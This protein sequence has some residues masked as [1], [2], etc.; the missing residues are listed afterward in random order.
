MPATTPVML[1]ASRFG[2]DAIQFAKINFPSGLGWQLM[3]GAAQD[4]HG[5]WARGGVRKAAD[6]DIDWHNR[7]GCAPN[8]DTG[9][10]RVASVDRTSKPR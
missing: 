6:L 3:L 8:G 4:P 5:D 2:S 9:R 10:S 7:V 1:S